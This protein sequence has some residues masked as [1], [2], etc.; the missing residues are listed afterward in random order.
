MTLILHIVRIAII[1][2]IFTKIYMLKNKNLKYPLTFSSWDEKEI[3]EIQ[4]L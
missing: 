2:K 1:K 4:K 3:K